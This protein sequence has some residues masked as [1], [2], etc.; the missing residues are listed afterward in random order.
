MKLFLELKNKVALLLMLWLWA[1]GAVAAEGDYPGK[2]AEPVVDY[3]A[4]LS[5]DEVASMVAA[6]KQFEDST[7]IQI[8]VCMLQSVG[9]YDIAEYATTLY[10][11]WGIGQQDKKNGVLLLVAK[12]DRK[13]FISTGYGM[14]GVLPDIVC[15]QIVQREIVPRFKAGDYYGGIAAATE[16]MMQLSKGEYSAKEYLTKKKKPKG[17]DWLVVLV[18]MGIVIIIIISQ[19]K[20][21]NRYA[22]RN[23]LGF[24]AAWTLLNAAS[25]RSSSNWSNWSGG[26]GSSNWGGGGWGG[27][28]GGSSGGGGAG[29]SW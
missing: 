4:T 28:G 20:R 1:A 23:N 5:A 26:G 19:L 3:T 2:P 12:A 17:N 16:K 27:F 24:W 10:N 18:L 22:H 6:I 9:G 25:N 29:G 14:E 11:K 13:V 21:V 15:K 8:A 7:S